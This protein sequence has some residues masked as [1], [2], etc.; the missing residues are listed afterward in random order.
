MKKATSK[1][2]EAPAAPQAVP[3]PQPA[4]EQQ[5]KPYDPFERALSFPDIEAP[6]SVSQDELGNYVDAL[7]AFAI[8]KA[9]LDLVRAAI[10]KKLLLY[11]GVEEGRYS[12]ELKGSE[13][14]VTE[15]CS[16]CASMHVPH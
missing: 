10:T 13:L 3:E 4:P 1:V 8:A 12:A 15:T 9:D 11:A 5:P 7:A 16:C 6:P 14:V 2:Q